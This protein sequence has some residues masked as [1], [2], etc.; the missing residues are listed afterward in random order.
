MN[1]I[2]LNSIPTEK[3]NLNFSNDDITNLQFVKPDFGNR[4]RRSPSRDKI[5]PMDDLELLANQKKIKSVDGNS[6][7]NQSEKK[8]INLAP[9][10]NIDNI[11]QPLQMPRQRSSSPAINLFNNTN[12]NGLN[13]NVINDNV[14]EI[15]LDDIMN[16]KTTR[17]PSFDIPNISKPIDSGAN[18]LFN[19]IGGIGMNKGMELSMPYVPPE[20]PQKTY[21]EIQNEKQDYIF[22]LD[23][24]R[25]Q[26]LPITKKFTMQ[27]S[28]EEMQ[29]E[30]TRLK[31]QREMDLSLKF[32]RK[33]LMGFI[34][35]IEYLNGSFNPFEIKLDGWSED[36]SKNLD[37][38]DDT[39]E[40]LHEKYKGK[41]NMAPELKLMFAVGGSAFW[42]NLNK[43]YFRNAPPGFEDVF[44]QN[45]DLMRHFQ[46]TVAN[47]SGAPPP[48]TGTNP[49]AGMGM[50]GMG[51]PAPPPQQNMGG[52]LAGMMGSM[53]SGNQGK[54]N[55]ADMND[56]LN[57][58]QM[59]GM[60]AQQHMAS[61]QQHAPP[62]APPMR[63]EMSGPAG[64][65]NILNQ[66]NP[67][68]SSVKESIRDADRYENFSTASE[69]DIMNPN[70][71]NGEVKSINIDKSKY[72]KKK[73]SNKSSDDGGLTLNL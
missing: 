13:T 62:P 69:K 2:N 48:F 28:L 23:R 30:Y 25:K 33:M 3:I 15:K 54:N 27:H 37:D 58:N 71:V 60:G 43:K 49:N 63:H 55:M 14:N 32:Q 57:A 65:N 9:K 16:I 8:T 70:N 21:G 36:V 6:V 7:G 64:L 18:N 12:N 59:N 53:F 47:M 29:D 44:R 45:P 1:E 72:K 40:E 17:N 51:M 46:E 73:K 31:S 11:E 34:T 5:V 42:Y 52:G 66:I 10:I 68:S 20:V 56:F 50:G 67:P 41:G 26:G 24:L 38:F 22:K 19:D 35:G 39:F 61:Q 4:D